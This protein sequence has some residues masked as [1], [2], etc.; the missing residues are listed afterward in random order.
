MTSSVTVDFNANLARFT[1][2]IDKATNDLNKFQSNAQRV[3]SNISSAFASLGVGLSVAGVIA[4]GKAIIDLGDEMND[5]SQRVGIN[6]KDLATWQLAAS[7]SGTTMESVARGVKGLS[8]FMVENG[9]ALRTAGIS[10]TDANGA[11]VQLADLFKAMPDG[12][13]KTALAVKLFGKAGMEMIPMLNMGSQGLR[14]AQEK[15]KAYGERLA[16]LA[17][18][19]DAFN[20]QMAELAL[21]SK[22]AGMSITTSLL[23]GLTGAVTWLNDL[24]AG[25]ERGAIA[26]EFL[27]EKTSAFTNLVPQLRAMAE[28]VGKFSTAAALAGVGGD[29]SRRTSRGNITGGAGDVAAFDAATEIFMNEREAQQRAKGLLGKDGGGGGKAPKSIGSVEDYAM[30]LNQAVAGAVTG[31]A[32]VKARELADQI[33]VLDKLFFDSGLDIDIY[34]SALEKMTGMTAKAAPEVDRLNQLL[35]ATP[36]AHLEAIRADMQL[37]AEAL[38]KGLINEQQFNEAAIAVNKMGEAVKEADDFARD[39]GLSFSSAFEDAIVGGKSFSD[40]LKGLANDIERIVVRK[41]VTE[42]IGGAISDVIK[43][44][45]IGKGLGDAFKGLFGFATG[46]DFTVGGA[47]GTDSQLVAFRATPGEQVS[48]RT[49]AQQAGGSVVIQQH[50]YPSPGVS[51]ADLMAAMVQAKNA[52]LAEIRNS[53]R[54][55]GVF[56]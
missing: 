54:R 4:Y 22:V 43:G 9:T 45:G 23:P 1:G 12:V 8:T 55:G 38:Q 13:E 27:T 40:V 33:D 52:A 47:G 17:P 24:K 49:P 51:S 2:A 26:M 19:A 53:Q 34:T 30:R 39:M 14:E 28:A 44:S 56:A 32:V 35:A 20:D 37:L 10:A 18:K 5:L 36:S 50:I 42:P 25:G 41:S 6:T 15:A 46:G 21:Q 31:S 3:S 7:Q 48:V 11:M 29:Q 16:A